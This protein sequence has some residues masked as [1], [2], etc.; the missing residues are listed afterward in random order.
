M[1]KSEDILTLAVEVLSKTWQ[2]VGGAGMEYRVQSV[3]E[4]VMIETF[5]R[6]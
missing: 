3:D 5:V 1:Q 2:G 6:L 4:R